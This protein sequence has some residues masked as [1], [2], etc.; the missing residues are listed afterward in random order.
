MPQLPEPQIELHLLS[1]FI[2]SSHKRSYQHGSGRQE[3]R[4]ASLIQWRQ[5]RVQLKPSIGRL[6][7]L[8]K[9]AS[10]VLVNKLP[11]L[12]L[13]LTDCCLQI[14]FQTEGDFRWSQSQHEAELAKREAYNVRMLSSESRVIAR[15]AALLQQQVRQL[16]KD[17]TSALVPLSVCPPPRRPVT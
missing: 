12:A 10:V 13:P 6:D 9:G 2:S 17:S 15:E 3:S 8:I 5:R 11:T 16:S 4:V 7:E 1:C 14:A